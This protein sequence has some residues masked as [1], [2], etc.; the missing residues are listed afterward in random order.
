MLCFSFIFFTGCTLGNTPTSKVENFLLNYQMLEN[1]VSTDY[2]L[3]SNNNALDE[4]LQKR[5]QNL[6]KKQY[7]NLSYEIKDEQI[8]GD[9]ATVEVQI[10]VINYHKTFEQYDLNNY[11]LDNYHK[12]IVES[13]ENEKETVV[14]TINFV[15]LRNK[16]GNWEVLPLESEDLEKILGMYTG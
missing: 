11:T 3:L 7:R 14:Y 15:V 12:M 1:D 13:L 4:S 6:I 2:R 16:S 8:D 10:K 5:Y 9:S